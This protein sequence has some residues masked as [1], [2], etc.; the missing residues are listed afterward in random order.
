MVERVNQLPVAVLPFH[1]QIRVCI[2][3]QR[4]A[5][6]KGFR[7]TT[8]KLRVQWDIK[9]QTDREVSIARVQCNEYKA[10]QAHALCASLRLAILL[11]HWE[12]ISTSPVD[13][14]NHRLDQL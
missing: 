13:T 5:F 1:I 11:L 10:S 8:I 2:T 14:W 6:F 3:Q 7:S 9:I 12:Q 4:N